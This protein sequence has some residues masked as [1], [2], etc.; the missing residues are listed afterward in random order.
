MLFRFATVGRFLPLYALLAVSGRG[1]VAG[2]R[3]PQPLEA[4]ALGAD[5]D[6]AAAPRHQSCLLRQSVGEGLREGQAGGSATQ[7]AIAQAD[8][9]SPRSAL[10][11][12]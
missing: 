11:Q 3:S 8:S 5:A 2:A 10:L 7:L 9:S 1:S 6:V 4:P 12:G